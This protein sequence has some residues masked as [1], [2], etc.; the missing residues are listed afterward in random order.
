[1][2]IRR[3][4]PLIL[5]GTLLAGALPAAAGPSWLLRQADLEVARLTGALPADTRD[6]QSDIGGRSVTATVGAD[7]GRRS[8]ALPMLMSLVVPGAGEVYL[9]HK[10]GFLQIALDAA[11]WYGAIH[12]S[13]KGQDKK[14]E[15]YAYADEHWLLGQ[16]D[17]AYDPAYLERQDANFNYSEVVGVGTDYPFRLDPEAYPPYTGLGLWVSLEDDRREYYENLGKW[18]QFV[19][20]W[21]DFEDPRDFLNTEEIDADNLR[22]PRTSQN[23]EV[24]RQMRRDSN[25]YY[26]KRD[27]FVYL[28]IA[29]RVFSVL[30]VAYLEGLLFGDDGVQGGEPANIELGGHQVNFFAEPIGFSRGVVGAT[31]SF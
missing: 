28:S 3:L 26:A 25:D 10:R 7:S 1:M 6:W 21:D 18:D 27:R 29:F 17:A 23:R 4:V 31:V 9:G 24:Y 12:N 14:D 11:S 20:G 8:P 19:F 22:D 2:R 30:Q 15:Y 13:N 5:I 16:L